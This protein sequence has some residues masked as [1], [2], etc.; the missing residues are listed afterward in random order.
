MVDSDRKKA[1]ENATVFLISQRLIADLRLKIHASN[2]CSNHSDIRGT[3][4]MIS[5]RT[6]EW[7]VIA[8][9]FSLEANRTHTRCGAISFSGKMF[10]EEN[11]V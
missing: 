4:R 6:P 1:F 8:D 9:I 7:S 5:L 2:L 3:R 10:G 11:T